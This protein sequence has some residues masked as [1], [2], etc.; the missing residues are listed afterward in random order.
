[1]CILVH[2]PAHLSISFCTAMRPDP[3]L[4]YACPVRLTVAQS[5]ALEFP[6]KR[7]LNVIFPG[8]DCNQYQVPTSKNGV[9]T[10]ISN[11]HSFSSDGRKFRSHGP[12]PPLDLP[13]CQL[14]GQPTEATD[15]LVHRRCLASVH[16][17]Y[18]LQ[19]LHRKLETCPPNFGETD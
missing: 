10:Y 4:Q 17:K 7:A 13:P 3:D 16:S 9:T 14:A 8:G 6:Q 19:E 18:S 12:L 1:M 11:S 15:D 2:S 5:K